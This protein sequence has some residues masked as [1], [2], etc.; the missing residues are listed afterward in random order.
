VRIAPSKRAFT[1]KKIGFKIGKKINEEDY[2]KFKTF[3][4]AQ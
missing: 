1:G 3:L 4:I 2:K